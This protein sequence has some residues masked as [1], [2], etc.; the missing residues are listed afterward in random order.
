MIFFLI[1]FQSGCEKR[2]CRTW[3]GG[4]GEGQPFCERASGEEGARALSGEHVGYLPNHRNNS[5][6]EDK[7]LDIKVA[8]FHS[9]SFNEKD[10]DELK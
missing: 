8:Y 9:R 5:H 4:T 6:S 1:F 10:P 2:I 3:V 7:N